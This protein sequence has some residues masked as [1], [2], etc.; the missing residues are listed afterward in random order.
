MM[1]YDLA[2]TYWEPQWKLPGLETGVC[3]PEGEPTRDLLLR[4][5]GTKLVVTDL[6]GIYQFN[7]SFNYPWQ[8]A[9]IGNRG[10]HIPEVSLYISRGMDDLRRCRFAVEIAMMAKAVGGLDLMAHR[11]SYF[12][13]V[14]G[15]ALGVVNGVPTGTGFGPYTRQQVNDAVTLPTAR[16]VDTI[17]PCFVKLGWLCRNLSVFWQEYVALMAAAY[18]P[19]EAADAAALNKVLDELIYERLGRPVSEVP[20]HTKQ[21]IRKSAIAQALEISKGVPATWKSA[22][23][24]NCLVPSAFSQKEF[25]DNVLTKSQLESRTVRQDVWN[26]V[27]NYLDYQLGEIHAGRFG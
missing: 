10:K 14:G 25:F 5:S 20:K 27:I 19:P 1:D 22:A 26:D 2:P 24:Y 7:M 3:S 21:G 13:L 4:L 18:T 23:L 17:L 8:H 9:H 6:P 11:D 16:R 15:R 12:V